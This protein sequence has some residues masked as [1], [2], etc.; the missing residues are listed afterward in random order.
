M[1]ELVTKLLRGAVAGV[2]GTLAMDQY[3][4][5]TLT[6]DRTAHLLFGVVVG[7]TE[8]TLRGTGE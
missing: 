4:A 3:D 5:D 7:S 6:R 8:A 2:A 1:T